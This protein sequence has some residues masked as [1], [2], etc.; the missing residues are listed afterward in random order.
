[1]SVLLEQLELLTGQTSNLSKFFN[2]AIDIE[3]FEKGPIGVSQINELL[4]TA[5]FDRISEAYFSL[6]CNG[7]PTTYKDGI[8]IDDIKDL[9]EKVTVIRK[10][11]ILKYGNFKYAFKKWSSM[12]QA[13]LEVEVSELLPP[14]PNYYTTRTEPLE[15][16]DFVDINDTYLLGEITGKMQKVDTEI[17]EKQKTVIGK[18]ENNFRKYLTYDHMDVYVATSMRKRK[19]YISVGTF[20]REVFSDSKIKPLKLR[21]F[22]PTQSYS[23]SRFCKGLIECLVLKRAKCSIYCVQE[24]DTFGKDSELAITLAQGKPVIAWVPEIKD[25][26]TYSKK[27][28]DDS[29][30]ENQEQPI[31]A[32]RAYYFSLFPDDA[33]NNPQLT[34]TGSVETLAVGITNLLTARFDLRAKILKEVHPLSLQVDINTGVAH[35]LIVV[36]TSKE[37]AD[38]LYKILHRELKFEFEE[39]VPD[40]EQFAC[41]DYIKTYILRETKTKSVY[42]VVIGDE[43]LTNAFWNFYFDKTD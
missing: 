36:R 8:K 32:L 3:R 18:G 38:I 31:I 42:R 29:I 30:L 6:L 39:I 23:K 10:L 19:D 27:L 17:V 2:E 43:L 28:I 7:Q 26:E 33:A 1:M 11:G 4:L 35:G 21:Y 34:Q 13:E 25:I 12:S 16:I 22:D 24:S 15:D 41:G 40:Y 14:R 5:G 20:I 9:T 37:C